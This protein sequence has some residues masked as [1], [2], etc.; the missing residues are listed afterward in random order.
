MARSTPMHTTRIRRWSNVVGAWV[1]AAILLVA[2]V[3][4]DPLGAFAVD[5][6]LT[7]E[8]WLYSIVALVVPFIALQLLAAPLLEITEGEWTIRNPVRRWVFPERCVTGLSDSPWGYPRVHLQ[9]GTTVLVAAMEE[10]NL[11]AYMGTNPMLD[12]L[13]AV[14]TV[15]PVSHDQSESAI[16]KEWSRPY[17][18]GCLVV[19]IWIGYVS[20][21]LTQGPYGTY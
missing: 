13:Q 6:H 17:W 14:H 7:V 8:G 2:C 5:G 16:R 9:G 18:G 20:Y 3:T 12:R 1:G 19:L 10:I 4:S 21:V 11:S 15:A